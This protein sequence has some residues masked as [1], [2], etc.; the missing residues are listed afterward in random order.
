MSNFWFPLGQIIAKFVMFAFYILLP[1]LIGLE[2]YG[3]FAYTQAFCFIIAQPIIELGLDMVITKWVSRGAE[4]VVNKAFF[5]RIISSLLA[6][7]VICIASLIFKTHLL[8][9]L[10]FTLYLIVM[11]FNNTIFAFF[12]GKQRF[13]YEAFLSPANKMLALISLI[14]LSN[15]FYLKSALTGAWALLFSAL[16]TWGVGLSLLKKH[17]HSQPTT[18]SPSYKVLLKEGITL[19]LT[20]ILWMLYFRIDTLMLGLMVNTKEVGWYSTAYKLMEGSFIIPATIMALCYPNLSKQKNFI[21]IF[22]KILFIMISLGILCSSLIYFL[23][24]PVITIL[25]GEKFQRSIEFLKILAFAVIPVFIGHLT[26]QSLI[27]LDK[28]KLYLYITLL[29]TLLNIIL[30]YFFIHLWQAV[31]AAYASIITEIFVTVFTG[32]YVW[33]NVKELNLK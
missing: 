11:T 30:N 2:E 7:I 18:I 33:I 25:Y 20:A 26:T 21:S 27:A 29:A 23:S 1:R 19:F 9:T 31:G 10:I 17:Y 4:D 16:L 12:R 8:L 6:S 28:S 24:H 22:P 32:G 14:I 15:L 5:I 3:R 13:I